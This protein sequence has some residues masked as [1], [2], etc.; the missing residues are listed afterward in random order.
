MTMTTKTRGLLAA[1]AFA[2]VAP[3]AAGAAPDALK[4]FTA[5]YQ[6][7]YMGLQANGVIE[8]L[9]ALDDSSATSLYAQAL[10]AQENSDWPRAY[11][12]LERIPTA[13]RDSEMTALH[14][15]AWVQVQA[16]RGSV[17]RE[18]GAW[19]AVF[20]NSTVGSIGGGHL[21]WQVIAQ[22]RAQLGGQAGVQVRRV[23]LGPSLGQCCGGE[24]TLQLRRGDDYTILDTTGPHF[25]YKPERLSME[26]GQ[27][28][29]VQGDTRHRFQ[30][31]DAFFVPAGQVHRFEHFSDD[32]VTWVVFWGPP[33][34][35]KA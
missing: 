3:L 13:S 4:P 19:M 15:T 20:A 23:A 10:F 5:D 32:F 26:S 7:S 8:G 29:F 35:E 22:A 11:A 25:T 28:E 31:G 24:V 14:D 27:G 9:R 33:G 12:L 17:P 21:E 6:A 30:A 34:G 1:A 2:L 16:T 18:E